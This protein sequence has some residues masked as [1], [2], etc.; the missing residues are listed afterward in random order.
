MTHL[1]TARAFVQTSDTTHRPSV[2]RS[3]CGGILFWMVG[4]KADDVATFAAVTSRTVG[5]ED[6]PRIGN[7]RQVPGLKEFCRALNSAP[8]FA[9]HVAV[10][11][12]SAVQ[13]QLDWVTTLL[14]LREEIPDLCVILRD[15]RLDTDFGHE[16]LPLCD[17]T[18]GGTLRADT[19][20]AYIWLAL[21]SNRR[22]QRRC[23]EKMRA[24][25]GLP[26]RNWTAQRPRA[27]RAG[28]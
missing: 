18:V 17:I 9:R 24:R 27:L 20:E 8:P 13:A 22:W 26:E 1:E 28:C 2:A 23:N 10:I 15:R 7:M 4:A 19:L 6:I 14:E 25:M 5:A 3:G 21:R 16:R 11:D 12:L